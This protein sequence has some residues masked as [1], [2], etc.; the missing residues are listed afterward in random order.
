MKAFF[1]G[2]S[3]PAL[4]LT[5]GTAPLKFF[6]VLFRKCQFHAHRVYYIRLRNFNLPK[7][8]ICQTLL[9][10]LSFDWYRREPCGRQFW[11]GRRP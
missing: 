5:L 10:V 9:L 6:L 7:T 4:R 2:A 8:L 11:P 3:K 1:A